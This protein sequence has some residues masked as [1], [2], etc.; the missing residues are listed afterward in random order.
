MKI[1]DMKINTI[2]YIISRENLNEDDKIELIKFVETAS[3]EQILHLLISG[4]I[5]SESEINQTIQESNN[6]NEELVEQKLNEIVG[7]ATLVAYLAIVGAAALVSAAAEIFILAVSKSYRK[8]VRY[9]HLK[10]QFD[11]CASN[12]KADAY[13]KKLKFLKDKI[14]LCKK[15]KDP[16]DCDLKVKR[17]INKV[18]KKL[19]GV[20]EE[21]KRIEPLVKSQK[22]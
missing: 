12:V 14:S 11:L 1:V 18:E 3:K 5:I 16:K 2:K 8:C 20:K 21:I 19:A 10:S 17:E 13:E 6:K 15:A 22:K 9:K 7:A 4:K